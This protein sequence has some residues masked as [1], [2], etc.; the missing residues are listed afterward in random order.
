MLLFGGHSVVTQWSFCCHSIVIQWSFGCHSVVIRWLIVETRLRLRKG[1]IL[2]AR[3]LLFHCSIV[4]LLCY[5][6][7]VSGFGFRVT[8]ILNC[9]AA[10]TAAA[11]AT[12][13]L[14]APS[15]RP[16]RF[17]FRWS[18]GCHSVVSRFAFRVP[19]FA[20]SASA[21]LNC[22]A[23]ATATATATILLLAPSLASLAVYPQFFLLFLILGIIQ[24][25]AKTIF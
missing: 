23:A 11:T 7:R 19:S 22:Q 4:K 16:L 21:T 14:F 1:K 25:L 24:L 18:F 3:F 12:I 17:I 2:H 15:L 9:Q 20:F 6:L 5:G 13:P 10:A 8:A